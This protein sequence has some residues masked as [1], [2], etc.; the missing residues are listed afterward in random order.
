MAPRFWTGYLKLSLVTCPVALQPATTDTEKVRFHTLNRATGQRVVS[1]YVDSVTNEAVNDDAEVKGYE[2]DDG[3]YVMFEDEELAA[4][5][6]ES[7]RSIDI[8]LFTSRD[9]IAWI[10]LDSCYFLLPN[11][12]VGEEAYAVIREAMAATETVGISRVVLG[13][14]ERAVMLEPRGKG[15]IAWTLRFGDEVRRPSIYFGELGKA[16]PDPQLLELADQL[17]VKKTEHWSDEFMKDPIQ[18]TRPA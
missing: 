2:I 9:E 12:P 17:V 8:D 4:V 3:R 18:G 7:A 13:R 1:R 5:G 6:L 15:I 10:W 11:D 14:R 16:K